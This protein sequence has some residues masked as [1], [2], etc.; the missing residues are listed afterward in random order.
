[1]WNSPKLPAKAP[2]PTVPVKVFNQVAQLGHF[3]G[4]MAWMF[5][6]VVL[7][8]SQEVNTLALLGGV[9]L[10]ALKEFWYDQHYEDEVVRGSNMEDFA[11]YCVGFGVASMVILI[12][13][14]LH[15][16]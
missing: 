5:G 7:L 11:F 12:S 4:G 14:W 8:E 9:C 6:W 3:A 16:V 13:R 15:S 10:A 1:M 2:D